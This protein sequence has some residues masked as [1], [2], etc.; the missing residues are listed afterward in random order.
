MSPRN[1]N[2]EKSDPHNRKN[3]PSADRTIYRLC[4]AR[5]YRIGQASGEDNS[6]CQREKPVAEEIVDSLKHYFPIAAQDFLNILYPTG[7]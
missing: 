7:L 2:K 3:E 4:Y 6:P 1:T 5:K